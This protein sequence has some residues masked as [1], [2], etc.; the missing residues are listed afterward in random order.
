M[1]FYS[2]KLYCIPFKKYIYFSLF[3][4]LFVSKLLALQ[5][6]GGF[7]RRTRIKNTY[8]QRGGKIFTLLSI[9]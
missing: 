9:C 5:K 4:L 1:Y 3:M 7:F 2:K 8:R 6:V